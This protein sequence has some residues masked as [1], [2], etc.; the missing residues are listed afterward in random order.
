M[1]YLSSSSRAFLLITMLTVFAG[2]AVNPIYQSETAMA[3]P[4][5]SKVLVLPGE[6]L[7]NE[8]K[9]FSE[10][11]PMA[12]ETKALQEQL[13]EALAEYMFENGHEYIDYGSSTTLDEHVRVIDQAAVIVD[14]ASN[15]GK[16]GSTR[17]YA[18]GKE[19]LDVL[20]SYDAD[21]VLFMD[22][23]ESGSSGGK[24]VMAILVTG[25]GNAVTQFG[26]R[27]ALFDIRDGQLV[28][29][30]D[31]PFNTGDYKSSFIDRSDKYKSNQIKN[32]MTDFPL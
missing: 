24:L 13:G 21:Y 9:A 11:E 8:R 7:V 25:A 18:L 28:W 5:T 14:A 4:L 3:V 17:F 29:S 19:S 23:S 31:K 22:Y 27:L 6:I 1:K 32:M 26:Y 16:S 2:C 15:K 10:A 20:S 30:N 12:E